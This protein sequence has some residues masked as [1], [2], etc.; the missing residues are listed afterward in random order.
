MAQKEGRDIVY[1]ARQD[2][3]TEFTYTLSAFRSF[4]GQCGLRRLL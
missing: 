2:A 1:V 3:P 4:A